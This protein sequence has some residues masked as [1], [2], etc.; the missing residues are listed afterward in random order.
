L[1]QV[2]GLQQKEQAW[3]QERAALSASL[4]TQQQLWQTFSTINAMSTPTQYIKGE[5]VIVVDADLD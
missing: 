4:S 2:A 3:L 1:A 5:D